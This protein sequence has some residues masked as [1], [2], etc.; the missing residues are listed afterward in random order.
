MTLPQTLTFGETPL[1]IVD[2]GGVPW[3][4]ARDIGR[5]LGYS[6]PDKVLTLFERNKD[7]FSEDMTATLEMR[8]G[9][10]PVIVRIF[11]PRGCHLLAM[12]SRTPRAK[13]FRRWVLDVLDGLVKAPP[14]VLSGGWNRQTIPDGFPDDLKEAM[15]KHGLTRTGTKRGLYYSRHLLPAP[16]NSMGKDALEYGLLRQDAPKALPA[17]SET[18]VRDYARLY[19]TLPPDAA[20]WNALKHRLFQASHVYGRELAAIRELAGRP[21]RESRKCEVET[22]FDSVMAPINTLFRA[23]EASEHAVFCHVSSA[24]D[25]YVAAHKFLTRG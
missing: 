14:S 17:A 7:E 9:S 21:F 1:S 25:G 11:S 24:L 12:F 13:E 23:A 10:G 2:R 15:R 22:Y 16:Y 18:T 5:A 19:K 3:L 4:Q 20:H 6:T 8:V